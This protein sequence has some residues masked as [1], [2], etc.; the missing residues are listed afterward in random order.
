MARLPFEALLG[1]E[2]PFLFYYPA[3]VASAW[4]GGWGPG[5]LATVLGAIATDYFW[6]PPR[7]EFGVDKSETLRLA[8]FVMA[9][10]TV[11]VLVERLH[12]ARE[13]AE[14]AKEQLRAVLTHAGDAIVTTDGA[15]R[16]TFLNAKGQILT[17][18]ESRE[19]VGQV[20][21]GVFFL[22]DAKNR[23]SINHV[24]QQALVEGRM[25]HLPAKLILVSKAGTEHYV[26]QKSSRIVAG[27][28]RSQGAV[29]LF[30]DW[31][32]S[33]DGPHAASAVARAGRVCAGATAA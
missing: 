23:Q 24:F 17:G 27:D 29:I 28:G 8:L 14:C 18:W 11:A 33:D 15:G 19:V 30:H 31:T 25:H 13:A 22:L 7:Y 3:V 20:F 21:G 32:S 9:S 5:V 16:I 4:L 2:S 12:R 26:E 10:V 6:M 1:I